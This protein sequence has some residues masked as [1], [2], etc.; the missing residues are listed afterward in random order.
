MAGLGVRFGSRPM[1]LIR[2]L[3]NRLGVGKLGILPSFLVAG[4]G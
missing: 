1:R 2:S 4:K 3:S